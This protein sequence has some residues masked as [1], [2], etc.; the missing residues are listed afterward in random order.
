MFDQNK[1]SIVRAE[2]K[3][4]AQIYTEDKLN[5]QREKYGLISVHELNEQYKR[6]LEQWEKEEERWFRFKEMEKEDE[7]NLDYLRQKRLNQELDFKENKHSI[8]YIFSDV[9]KRNREKRKKQN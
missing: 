2:T 7:D 1:D 8:Q 5:L 4:Y 9:E 3:S 6:E